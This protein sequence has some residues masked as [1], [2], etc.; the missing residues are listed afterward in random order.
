[1]HIFRH[2]FLSNYWWQRSDIW[3]QAS[4][5]F[6]DQ[7]D[8]YFLFAEER[9]CHKLTVH[10]VFFTLYFFLQ[11]WLYILVIT[12]FLYARLETGPYYVIGYG[13]RVGIH[14]GFRTQ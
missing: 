1:M 10:L 5:R 11:I 3:S 13:G 7:S 6:L 12:S 8:S 14:T 2:I 4:Y 9:G